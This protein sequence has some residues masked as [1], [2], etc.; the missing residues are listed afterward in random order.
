MLLL[1]N[2]LFA[3]E[4]IPIVTPVYI[5]ADVYNGVYRG[6][7][8]QVFC[9]RTTGNLV[10][11]RYRYYC[12]GPDPRRIDAATSIDGGATWTIHRDINLGVGAE[13]HGRY[14]S[15]CGTSMTPIIAYG[16]YNPGGDNRSI[17]PIVTH[18]N[19]GWSGREFINLYVD[20]AGTA[21]T[22][23]YGQYLSCAVA[24]DNE[25]L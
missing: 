14:P 25:N 11:A 22:V 3:Q 20:N 12:T 4:P 17:R 8:S 24:P 2:M 6:V 7:Q 23:L 18:K 15:V 5:D 19:G 1:A 21:D 10:C 13:M 9:E 16:D